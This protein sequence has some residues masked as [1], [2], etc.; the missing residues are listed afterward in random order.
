MLKLEIAKGG[1]MHQIAPI[2]TKIK[3]L[4]RERD[5][6]DARYGTDRFEEMI[7]M[8]VNLE[9]IKQDNLQAI[10]DAMP[11]AAIMPSEPSMV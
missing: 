8:D 5:R 10:R 3:K 4:E 6:L 7:R 11:V 2:Q 9:E 1:K